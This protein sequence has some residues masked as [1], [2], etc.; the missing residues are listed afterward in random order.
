M[1]WTTKL[2]AL[3]ACT[4]AVA[5]ARTQPDPQTAWDNCQ[6]GDWMLWCAA[7]AGIDRR[8][9]VLAACDCAET[10]ADHADSDTQMSIVWTIETARLWARGEGGIDLGDVRAAV[11]AAADVRAA[12]Y[13]AA[14][15]AVAV[16]YASAYAAYAAA[17]TAAYGAAD[18]YAA[19]AAYAAADAYA[20]NARDK[21]LAT[22]AD[23]C[24]EHWPD[25]DGWLKDGSK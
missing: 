16:S 11:Y 19:N 17:Y 2:T 8:S 18:A 5:W 10:A 3:D 23:I 21:A 4:D 20:A 6:R 25:V 1:T 7:R 13:A 9:L 24:R 12:V 22:C 15:A 14:A